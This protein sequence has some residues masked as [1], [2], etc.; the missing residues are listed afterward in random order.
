M[1]L[2]IELLGKKAK[3]F[4]SIFFLLITQWIGD[5]L[6]M[7]QSPRIQRQPMKGPCNWLATMFLGFW[8]LGS[9]VKSMGR[10][11]SLRPI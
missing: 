2:M 1:K 5:H 4:G 9:R 11:L 7:S 6:Y 8:A 10:I 3:K